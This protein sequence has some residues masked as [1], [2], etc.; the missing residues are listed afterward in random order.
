MVLQRVLHLCDLFVFVFVLLLVIHG[1]LVVL[2][3]DMLW[4]GYGYAAM[5]TPGSG[6]W[7]PWIWSHVINGHGQVGQ[8]LAAAT[9]F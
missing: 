2:C 3:Y 5:S 8:W 1:R 6:P 9:I 7:L 4:L